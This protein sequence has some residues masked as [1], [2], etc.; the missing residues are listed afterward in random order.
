VEARIGRKN[1][2]DGA[3]TIRVDKEEREGVQR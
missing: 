3:M 2:D 1:E